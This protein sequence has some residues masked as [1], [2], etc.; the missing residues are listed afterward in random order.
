V[1]RPHGGAPLQE[2]AHPRGGVG[3]FADLVHELV[4]QSSGLCVIEGVGDLDGLAGQSH[5]DRRIGRDLTCQL[6]HVSTGAG[7]AADESERDGGHEVPLDLGESEGR[8]RRG[9][10]D[11]ARR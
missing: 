2:G 9:R 5:C 1:A 11:V 10:D 6:T 4:A 8:S 7:E 3:R